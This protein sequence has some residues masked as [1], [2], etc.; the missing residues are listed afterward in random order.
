[1]QLKL[2]QT[3][4]MF[5]TCETHFRDPICMDTAWCYNWAQNIE[6]SWSV[7]ISHTRPFPVLQTLESKVTAA[8]CIFLAL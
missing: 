8:Q 4:Y 1:M 3:L 6:N 2:S 5:Q 7:S